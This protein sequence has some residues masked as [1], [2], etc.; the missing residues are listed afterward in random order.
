[1]LT[2]KIMNP[3][4]PT[5]IENN[6]ENVDISKLSFEQLKEAQELGKKSL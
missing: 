1:M 5:K 4:Q 3:E 2:I 6:V